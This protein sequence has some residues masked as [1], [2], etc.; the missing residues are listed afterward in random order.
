M[1]IS[2]ISNQDLASMSVQA[3]A[4]AIET[5]HQE[6]ALLYQAMAAKMSKQTV[7]EAF[8]SDDN[9]VVAEY[10]L[11]V[12]KEYPKILSVDFDVNGFEER[13][14]FFKSIV[15]IM[16]QNENTAVLL[17]SARDNASKDCSW[18]VSYV[19]RRVKE[20]EFNPIFK[21]ILQKAPN[22]RESYA[23]TTSDITS[24]V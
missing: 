22:P 21:L 24:K 11:K 20:L 6:M 7:G 5:H 4:T 3:L 18:N 19:R 12:A 2:M 8:L 17:K 10:W 23:K 1:N 9:I 13:T 14:I 15:S 16:A